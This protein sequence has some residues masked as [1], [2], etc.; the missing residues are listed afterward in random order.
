MAFETAAKI[1]NQY[2]YTGRGPLDSKALVNSYDQLLDKSTWT[3]GSSII[4]YNGMVTAVWLNKTDTTK[5]GIYFLHDTE[6]TSKF[7]TPDV[8][9]AANWHKLCTIAE[10]EELEK[11]V[12]VKNQALAELINSNTTAIATNTSILNELVISIRTNTEAIEI[13]NGDTNTEGSI[14]KIVAD[15][16]A[17]L[18]VDTDQLP[19]A[20]AVKAGAVKAS[21]EILVAED[22]TMELG[23]VSTD[24]LEQG[25]DTLVL[26][27]GSAQVAE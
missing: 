20:T 16:I 24:K 14:Q 25:N 3:E 2:L 6:V 5:N 9:K 1:G 23:V 18:S 22:G 4:A 7:K 27:G 26:N 13:L 8:T 12:G 17:K 15:A 21:D 19:I 10:L 11:Q